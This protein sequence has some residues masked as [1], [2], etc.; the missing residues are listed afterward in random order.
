LEAG[1]KL[2]K[3]VQNANKES[4]K[5]SIAPKWWIFGNKFAIFA[6]CGRDCR[7]EE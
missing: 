6:D 5:R 1:S 2:S 4:K 3:I 7:E